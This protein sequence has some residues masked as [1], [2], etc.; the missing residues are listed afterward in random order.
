MVLATMSAGKSTFVNSLVGSELLHCANEATTASLASIENTHHNTLPSAIC[1]ASDRSVVAQ[2]NSVNAQELKAWNADENVRRIHVQAPFSGTYGN[3]RGLVLHDT[4]GPNNS[5][6]AKHSEVA[7]EALRNTNLDVVCYVLNASQLGIT[8][9]QQLLSELKSV[10]KTKPATELIFILNKVDLLD[11][12]RGESVQRLLAN[13]SLYLENNGFMQPSLVPT[14]S[15][16]ALLVK[17]HISGA[18]LSLKERSQLRRSI[19]AVSPGAPRL[20][21]TSGLPDGI[22]RKSLDALRRM[23]SRIRLGQKLSNH[24]DEL[25]ALMHLLAQSG[26]PTVE[27]LLLQKQ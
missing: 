23:K 25:G 21:P 7:F 18:V 10:L 17:R 22:A 27:T 16:V 13:T 5:Q 2:S 9:D 8:D 12:E 1:Y 19:E 20:P 24:P 14:M 4:P 3:T 26:I 11:P 6:N 15:Q